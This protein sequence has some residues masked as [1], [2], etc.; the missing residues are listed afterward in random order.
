MN[1]DLRKTPWDASFK[2]SIALNILEIFFFLFGN[3]FI[4]QVLATREILL[5]GF[6]LGLSKMV[7]PSFLPGK[8]QMNLS[9]SKELQLRTFK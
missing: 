8:K 5:S 9:L 6:T 7:F 4:V 3:P 1:A 2:V